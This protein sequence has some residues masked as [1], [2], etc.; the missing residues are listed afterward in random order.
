[1]GYPTLF[2]EV[3]VGYMYTG[4]FLGATLGFILIGPIADWSVRY[5]TRKNNGVFE[6]EFRLFLV[7]PQAL[8]GIIGVYM[9]GWTSANTLR[10]GWALPDFFFG[11]EVMGMII[12]AVAASLYIV[13]AHR[14]IAVEAFTAFL[15]F[16]N[17]FS[18][19]LTTHAFNWLLLEGVWKT[20]WILGT[21][22]VAVCALT[23]PMC[24]SPFFLPLWS[25]GCCEADW[26]GCRYFR[27]AE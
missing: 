23:I 10:Y 3:E 17:F 6:P 1:M 18:Y 24:R 12:G 14:G 9:F 11:M 2:S 20:F 16:K 19:A 15:L 4:A 22:Q 13:D 21:V 25:F 26:W 27:Q 7:I 8:T 5:L